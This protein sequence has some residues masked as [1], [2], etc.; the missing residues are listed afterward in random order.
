MW[1]WI[2]RCFLDVFV[3]YVF[4]CTSAAR[5]L[6]VYIDQALKPRWGTHAFGCCPSHQ[7]PLFPTFYG[8]G[9]Q[10]LGCAPEL[11]GMSGVALLDAMRQVGCCR[12]CKVAV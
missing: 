4:V 6:R 11:A 1:C 2:F 7:Q 5:V 12:C 9:R 10:L 8:A 3:A